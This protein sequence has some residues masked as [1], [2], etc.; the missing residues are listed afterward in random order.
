MSGGDPRLIGRSCP[1]CGGTTWDAL[2]DWRKRVGFSVSPVACANCGLTAQQIGIEGAISAD[3]IQE[4]DAHF[5]IPPDDLDFEF[6]EPRDEE[7]DVMIGVRIRH[8][9]S[10]ICVEATSHSLRSDNERAAL[11]TLALRLVD[12]ET[13]TR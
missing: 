2:V 1:R 3:R 8:S 6:I 7:F 9:P 5:T 10:G 12:R 4:Q 11:Q 13:R